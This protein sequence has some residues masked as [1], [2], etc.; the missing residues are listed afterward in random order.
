MKP[1]KFDVSD[2]LFFTACTGNTSEIYGGPNN[3]L[4]YF[5]LNRAEDKA[6]FTQEFYSQQM[7]ASLSNSSDSNQTERSSGATL[8]TIRNH[9]TYS[10]K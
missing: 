10:T 9:A 2:G 7:I 8:M 3:M 5:K 6:R 4:E 1:G